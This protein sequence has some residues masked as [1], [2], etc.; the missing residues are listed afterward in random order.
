MSEKTI[1]NFMEPRAISRFELF[2]T[3]DQSVPS[4]RAIEVMKGAFDE[5]LAND[6]KP[7]VV[8]PGPK[9]RIYRVS[10][11]GIEYVVRYRL[12]PAD[13]S[14][15]EGR[16]LVNEAVVRHLRAAGI[17]LAVPPRSYRG[18]LPGPA[19]ESSA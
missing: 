5:L 13:L 16:H 8:K 11:N 2:F 6:E 15:N 14:P 18:N 4:E 9:V 3:V 12:L 17:D 1:T 19:E 7:F 10:E